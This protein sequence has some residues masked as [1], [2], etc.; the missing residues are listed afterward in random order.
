VDSRLETI[1]SKLR[2][3]NYRITPQRLAV[4]RILVTSRAHPSADQVYE[5]VRQ[6]VPS[7]SLATIYKTANLLKKLGE[8]NEL[9]MGDGSSRFDG[10]NPIPH[11]HVVCLE[12]HSV[13]DI[14]SESL[15]PLARK[16]AAQTGYKI[17]SHRLDFFGLC[18]RC[19]GTG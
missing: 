6:Q 17:K 9:D 4:I 5:K 3:R 11:P 1:I 13:M 19:Q 14:D 8:L 15:N 12:C 7:I 18:P 2:D 16:I 10:F